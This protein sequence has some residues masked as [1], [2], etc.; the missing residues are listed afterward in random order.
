M[1]PPDKCKVPAA[2]WRAVAA[3]GI[4]PAALLRQAR[5]PATIHLGEAGFV[6]TA[7]FFALWR[8]LEALTGDPALGIKFVA[9]A[10]TAAHPPS[11]LAAFHARDYCDGL[12]RLARFKRLCTP[13]QFHFDEAAGACVV[14]N[15][16]LHATEPEPPIATDVAFATLVELGRRGT[17]RHLT[18]RRVE[19]LHARP[20]HE[21]HERYFGCEVRFGAARNA[22]ILDAADLDRPFPGHNPELLAMLTPSL[23]AAL[24]EL[25]ARSSMRAQVKVVLKRSLPSGRPDLADVARELGTSERTLQRRITDE[26]ATFRELLVEA[27]QE[28]GRQLLADPNTDIDE[29]ACLL[30]YQDTSSFYRAF[31]DWEGMTPNKWRELNGRA[32]ADAA[33]PLRSLH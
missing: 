18:P 9:G 10:A 24:G 26:G 15:L 33:E 23:S 27:R 16:W 1:I 20:G 30:G 19:Y 5:L 4:P 13:E 6:T 14:T 12:H 29:V 3:I 25:Q 17:G 22:L 11:S 28:L 2:F 7:Q 8:G 31:R 32:T 21:E